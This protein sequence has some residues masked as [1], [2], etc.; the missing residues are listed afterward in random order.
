MTRKNPDDIHAN[1]KKIQNCVYVFELYSSHIY[2]FLFDSRFVL[3]QLTYHSL[4]FLEWENSQFCTIVEGAFL[5][6]VGGYKGTKRNTN[7]LGK[8][9][10]FTPSLILQLTSDL[11]TYFDGVGKCN[12]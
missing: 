1:K 11:F 12:W 3:F 7:H 2:L 4:V 6:G 8:L 9:L 10:R 5:N